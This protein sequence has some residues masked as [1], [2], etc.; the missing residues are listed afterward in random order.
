MRREQLGYFEEF[1]TNEE[2]MTPKCLGTRTVTDN[3]TNR[4][5]GY[6]GRLYLTLTNDFIL[7]KGPKTV[8][9]KASIKKPKMV[10]TMLHLFEGKEI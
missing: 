3:P 10:M 5:M 6:A 7:Q 8:T 4:P 9:Y 1:I 2:G